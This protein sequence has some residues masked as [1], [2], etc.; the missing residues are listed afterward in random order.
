MKNT[1]KIFQGISRILLFVV[2]LALLS[3]ALVFTGVHMAN[4]NVI[5]TEVSGII[6]RGDEGFKEVNYTFEGIEHQVR[7]LDTYFRKLGT[8]DDKIKVYVDNN[9]PGRAFLTYH[10]D[11]LMR[12]AGILAGWGLLLLIILLGERQLMGRMRKLEE[13]ADKEE[14]G[15]TLS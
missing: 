15:T 14:N 4:K 1:V 11:G 12:T 13:L 2:G 6:V 7:P 3:G 10:G 9:R 8:I 5:K